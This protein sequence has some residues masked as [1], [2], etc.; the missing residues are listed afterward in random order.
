[1]HK[2]TT[3]TTSKYIDIT[4]ERGRKDRRKEKRK[5]REESRGKGNGERAP[6]ILA[7]FRPINK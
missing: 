7:K 4:E 5:K 2:Q 6:D 1:M 3:N